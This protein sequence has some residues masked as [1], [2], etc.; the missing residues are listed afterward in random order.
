MRIERLNG[1]ADLPA[2]AWNA[3]LEG[4]DDPFTRHEFLA[5]LER[6]GCVGGES[7]WYPVHQL[8]LD[9]AGRLLGAVPLYA[10]T[11]SWGEFVFDWSWAQAVQR[12]GAEYYPKLVGAVPSLPPHCRGSRSTCRSRACT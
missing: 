2:E 6:H 8:L 9:A 5:A 3:L 12:S 11:H 7:G 10:Q 1:L 4:E